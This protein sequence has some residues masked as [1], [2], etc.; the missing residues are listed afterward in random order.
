MRLTDKQYW[1]GLY[2][3]AG[4][5]PVVAVPESRVKRVIKRLLGER[6]MDLMSAYD[7]YLLWKV[8]LPR[9]L[10]QSCAGLLAL[11]VGSA[12]GDFLV[13]FARTFGVTPFGVE[14]S[15]QGAERNRAAFIVAGLAPDNVIEADFL[16]ECFQQDYREHFDIVISRGFIEH[17]E[18]VEA[19]VAR[20][21]DVLRPGGLLLILIPNLRGVYYAW[22]R[23]FN[24]SQLPLHNLEIM[25]AERFRS[26]FTRLEVDSLRCSHF[27]TFSFWLFTAPASSRLISGL[28]RVLLIIQRGLNVLFRLLFSWRGFETAAFSPNLIFVGRKRI[29]ERA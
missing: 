16:S 8:V 17:F 9:Y 24:P 23:A 18:D 15:H 11:E 21:V 29:R 12:P 22:T 13:R 3:D 27:G 28:I 26:L 19:V 1:D 14:Y 4:V 2:T 5:P 6:L 25:E 20:H 10:P 7:D